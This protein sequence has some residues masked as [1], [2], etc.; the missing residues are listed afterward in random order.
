MRDLMDKLGD[1]LWSKVVEDRRTE[2]PRTIPTGRAWQSPRPPRDFRFTNLAALSV[3][4]AGGVDPD[5]IGP[6]SL[7]FL[8][9]QYLS[10][11]DYGSVPPAIR[12]RIPGTLACRDFGTLF[13]LLFRTE[14]VLDIEDRAT[15]DLM[16]VN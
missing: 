9:F 15:M 8:M 3:R 7:D 11:Y 2:T 6:E 10:Q 12:D 1:W 14:R 16:L 5:A 4:E 13:R